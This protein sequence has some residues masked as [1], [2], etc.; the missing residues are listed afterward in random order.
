[1]LIAVLHAR[2]DVAGLHDDDADPEM[3]ELEVERLRQRLE[4]VFRR[5]VRSLHRRADLAL[6]RADVDQDPAPP[7]APSWCH[8]LGHSQWAQRVDLEHT[9]EGLEG[10]GLE[11]A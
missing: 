4:R 1:M 2:S 10:V 9:A 7:L 5:R 6:H 11:R 8:R 3:T